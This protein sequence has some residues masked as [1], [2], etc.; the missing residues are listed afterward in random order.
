MRAIA[1][2]LRMSLF[3]LVLL[4]VFFSRVFA[5]IIEVPSDVPSIQGG[6]DAALEGDTVLVDTGRY[7]ENVD[8]MGKNVVL[9]SLFL[10]TGDTS[11]I[12][13]TVID[14]NHGGSVVAFGNEENSKAVLCGFTITNG[15]ASHGGG[16]YCHNSRPTLRDLKVIG[17][18]ASFGGG[19]YCIDDS[20]TIL[21]VTVSH[22]RAAAV[23]SGR[24]A[25]V[26]S[27]RSANAGGGI[28]IK[29]SN[30]NLDHVTVNGNFAEDFG[31]GIFLSYA[32]PR[33]VHVTLSGNTA[34]KAGGGIYAKNG[35]G[36]ILVNTI[37]WDD[38]PEE[39][40]FLSNGDSNTISIVYSDIRGGQD[41]IAT[42][43]NATIRWLEGNIVTDPLFVDPD[44]G[45]LHLQ[46]GSACIDAGRAFYILEGD[47]LVNLAETSYD[48]HAP[49]MGSFESSYMTANDPEVILPQ[50]FTLHQ[51]YPNPFNHATVIR[52]DLPQATEVELVICDILGRE[53]ATL[54]S[55]W[56]EEGR[57]TITWDAR[58]VPS[59]IYIYRIEAGDFTNSR[60]LILLR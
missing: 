55:S 58:D 39:I 38:P 35:S 33:L 41:E 54:V 7:V 15:Y 59:G 22:N 3:S 52:Y 14:G 44:N 18:T 43:N 53:V 1:V 32:R 10:V 5:T 60:K 4:V 48:G 2:E 11:Y 29:V 36:P 56:Q 45:D 17:N 51:N 23:G 49:D 57:Q 8:F 16:I 24:A 50:G 28:F 42:N 20:P 46:D 9:G 30:P 40:Y 37:L 27:G 47:T 25:A 21:N 26:G 6:I 31:G 34:G 12:S 19:I 13:Q